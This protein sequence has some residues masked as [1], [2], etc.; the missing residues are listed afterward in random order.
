VPKARQVLKVHK[1]FK[2]SLGLR[3][4]LERKG[5]KGHKGRPVIPAP[6]GTRVIL[7]LSGLSDL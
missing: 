6:K 2:A 5:L 4:K 1:A 3:A 7:E